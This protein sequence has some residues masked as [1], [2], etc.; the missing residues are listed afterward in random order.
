[1][2]ML[3]LGSLNQNESH[4][5]PAEPGSKQTRKAIATVQHHTQRRQPCVPA[6]Q[7]MVFLQ[8]LEEKV[9]SMH[10]L[11]GSDA[12]AQFR[13]LAEGSLV[14]VWIQSMLPEFASALAL[15]CWP[16]AVPG[17]SK[18]L[19]FEARS[20]FQAHRMTSDDQPNYKIL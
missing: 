6:G 20:L 15:G 4:G 17:R 8:S 2:E 7:G 18:T 9:E 11:L 5:R 16:A 3:S 1:M 10:Y 14:G 12:G 19:C 13:E